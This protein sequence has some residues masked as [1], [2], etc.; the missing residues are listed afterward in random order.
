MNFERGPIENMTPFVNFNGGF[1]NIWSEAN[2]KNTTYNINFMLEVVT[3]NNNSV[4]LNGDIKYFNETTINPG[5][6]YAIDIGDLQI[7]PGIAFPITFSEGES[8]SGAFIYLSF[9]HPF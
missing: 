5:L 3:G 2:Y 9:E 4:D 1:Q 7:V 8:T 6:R